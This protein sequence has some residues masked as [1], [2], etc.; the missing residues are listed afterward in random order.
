M[1][2][3][4]YESEQKPSR[5]VLLGANGFIGKNL[6]ELLEKNNIPTQGFTSSD[7]DLI[8]ASS[9]ESLK[10][11]LNKDDT[12]VFLSA[13]TPDRGR[14]V[15]TLMKNLKMAQ[16]VA[17]YL[18]EGNEVG[19]LIYMSSDAVFENDSNINEESKAVAVDLYGC[20]HIAREVI[21]N[22]AC[23]KQNIPLAVLR[24]CPV[25]GFG[26][27]HNSYGPNR[28]IRTALSDKKIQFFG[29]GEEMRDHIAVEDLCSLVQNV[30]QRKSTG[31]LNLATGKSVSFMDVAK[32]IKNVLPETELVETERK[33]EITHRHYDNREIMKAF[34]N[35]KFSDMANRLES[36]IT[37]QKES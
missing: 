8:D 10:K 30:I 26:D 16:N 27:T 22:T 12:V 9:K 1:L 3:H 28:Y 37:R 5:V 20:M 24:P 35:F 33:N 7:I 21:L 29:A 36:M 17:E 15:N 14:D 4:Q 25:Y 34:P 32:M 2:N 13:L 31:I 11:N 6:T 18:E 19:H 23:Q